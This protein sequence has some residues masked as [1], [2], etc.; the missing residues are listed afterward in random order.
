VGAVG[1]IADL[2]ALETV[3]CPLVTSVA[4]VDVDREVEVLQPGVGHGCANGRARVE[5]DTS[6]NHKSVPMI[7]ARKLF[8]HHAEVIDRAAPG[9][10]FQPADL[11]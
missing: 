2:A 1:R 8:E 3:F 5:V 6:A 10:D 4:T 9:R 11:A 7:G